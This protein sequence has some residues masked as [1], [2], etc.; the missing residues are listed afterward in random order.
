MSLPPHKKDDYYNLERRLAELKKPDENHDQDTLE[1]LAERFSKVFDRRPVISLNV[2][3]KGGAQKRSYELPKEKELDEEEIE[4]FLLS[5]GNLLDENDDSLFS[6]EQQQILDSLVTK[7]MGDDLNTL[8]N[9]ENEGEETYLIR[10]IREE[11]LL[12]ENY[13]LNGKST[14]YNELKE[15]FRLLKAN[16]ETD[17]AG[18]SSNRLGSPPKAIDFEDFEDDPDTWCCICNEDATI[19]CRGCHGDLYCDECFQEGHSGESS[20]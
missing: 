3:N 5:E 11:A 7:V 14:D 6:N 17:D 18:I 4:N 16:S 8:S 9:F 2:E 12:E 15:R 1:D 13:D 19:K 10:Q 20:D